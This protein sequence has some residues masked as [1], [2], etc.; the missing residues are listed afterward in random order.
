MSRVTL[1]AYAEKHSLR[2]LDVW[3]EDEERTR[4]IITGFSSEEEIRLCIT[5]TKGRACLFD[6]TTKILYEELKDFHYGKRRDIDITQVGVFFYTDEDRPYLREDTC[7]RCV[8]SSEYEN[9]NYLN[10]CALSERYGSPERGHYCVKFQN[11][12]SPGLYYKHGIPVRSKT[13]DDYRTKAQWKKVHREVKKGAKPLHMYPALFS[14]D[15]EPYYLIE[16]TINIKERKKTSLN[17]YS[18]D[19]DMPIVFTYDQERKANRKVLTGFKSY[20]N[21]LEC[22]KSVKGDICHFSESDGKLI[23]LGLLDQEKLEGLDLKQVGV[24]VLPYEERPYLRE[25]TC[26]RCLHCQD[27]KARSKNNYCKETKRSGSTSRGHYC[28]KFK[29]RNS[30]KLYYKEDGI[31]VRSK[32]SMD[33]RTEYQWDSVGRKVKDGEEGL[34]MYASMNTSKKYVYYLIK[35]T[36]ECLDRMH[37]S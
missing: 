8:H 9:L 30:K 21:V 1:Q 5:A 33:Y 31:P 2:V 18:E 12:N 23:F 17:A 6:E 7:A 13:S 29:N 36:E 25:D 15:T 22:K 27:Y 4:T 28:E 35:Q 14:Y 20:D 34:E 3:H 11:V 10:V 37:V 16:Q 32:T 19:L 24:C 26:A